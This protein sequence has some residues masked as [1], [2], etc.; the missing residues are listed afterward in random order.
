[1]PKKLIIGLVGEICS[2]KDT[3]ADYL[4]K[5]Y[6]A[7][8]ISFSQPLRDILD[9]LSLPQTRI[10]MADLGIS[11]RGAFGQDLLSKVIAAEVKMGKK[12]IQVLPNVRLESDIIYLKKEP[13]FVLI[14]V[15]ADIKTR[16][17]RIKKRGQNT[18]DKS[19]TWAG[20]LK[21]A[22]LPTEIQIRQLAK[23][24]KYKLDNNGSYKDLEKQ[25]DALI[26]KMG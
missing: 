10:N 17:E 11:L 23:K 12:K 13:G 16:F 2:G 6:G 7:E 18:D 25:A 4:K 22:K 9:R 26:K 5:K 20:F 1:M 19:K 8:T 15:D 14:N 21:D 24:C 3:V